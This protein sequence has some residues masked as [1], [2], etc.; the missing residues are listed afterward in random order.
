MSGCTLWRR[1]GRMTRGTARSALRQRSTR[2]LGSPGRI[3]CAL[4]S[5]SVWRLRGALRLR[6]AWRLRRALRL[7]SARRRGTLL[8]GLVGGAL[9]AL[10]LRVAGRSCASHWCRAC[11]LGC[12]RC[13]VRCG[14]GSRASV[15]LGR[16]GVSQ[17]GKRERGRQECGQRPSDG[18]A[19]ARCVGRSL[20]A[21]T[22]RRAARCAKFPA[23]RPP[24]TAQTG[25]LSR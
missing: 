12:R 17:N 10:R 21:F 14:L 13:A 11:G 24:P 2:R 6:S 5:R 7:R 4:R 25:Y 22:L 1:L 15:V 20:H 16:G 18:R 19:R 9:G 3:G 8:A 23:S